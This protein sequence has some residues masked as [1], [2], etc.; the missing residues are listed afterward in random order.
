[1]NPSQNSM[2]E[3]S[4][5]F[6]SALEGSE[7]PKVPGEDI[8]STLCDSFLESGFKR[9]HLELIDFNFLFIVFHLD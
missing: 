5:L 6:S 1:M 9:N 4:V 2:Q 8:S 3:D 7:Q